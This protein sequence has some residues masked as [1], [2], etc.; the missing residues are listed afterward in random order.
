MARASVIVWIGTDGA[1][2]FGAAAQGCANTQRRMVAV[3]VI[4]AG[5]PRVTCEKRKDGSSWLLGP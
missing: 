4:V 1:G 3:A 5:P 2:A